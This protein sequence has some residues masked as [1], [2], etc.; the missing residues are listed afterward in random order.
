MIWAAC[1]V[2][3][4]VNN[5]LPVSQMLRSQYKKPVT[6]I[7]SGGAV[8]ILTDRGEQ[9]IKVSSV[10]DFIESHEY[11]EAFITGMGAGDIWPSFVPI[12]RGKCPTIVLQDY[13]GNGVFTD[14]ARLLYRPDYICVNDETDRNWVLKAWPEFNPERIEITG[15]PHF[16]QYA[17][18]DVTATS[19]GV[20]GRLGLSKK[21]PIILFLGERKE[22]AHALSELTAVLN[23][24]DGLDGNEYYFLPRFHPCMK[25]DAPLEL[26]LCEEVLADFN[27]GILMRDLSACTTT[28][29]IASASWVISMCSTTLAEASALRKPNISILYPEHG[30]KVFLEYTNGVMDESPFIATGCSEKA[31][32]R[33]QLR[34]LLKDVSWVKNQALSQE[35]TFRLDGKNTQRVVEFIKDISEA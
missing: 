33:E 25:D 29:L 35:K 2:P 7:A 1:N 12:L 4:D 24:L 32:N 17:H 20:R 3:G 9:F 8:G 18:L 27:G 31:E 14:W 30:Q 15:Y 34:R 16:D 10:K 22:T 19:Q 13:W 23:D 28:E 5:V 11:P 21:G 6:L 26:A